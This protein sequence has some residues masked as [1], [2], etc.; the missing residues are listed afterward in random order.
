MLALISGGRRAKRNRE[1]TTMAL[2]EAIEWENGRQLRKIPELRKFLN[3]QGIFQL[4]GL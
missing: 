2:G 1:R 3:L 4:F